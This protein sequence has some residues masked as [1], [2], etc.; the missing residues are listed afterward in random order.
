MPNINICFFSGDISRTGGT[1]RV[2][3]IIAN[4]LVARG[5]NV[6]ILSA[7]GGNK[8]SFFIEPEVHL[9]SL[10]MDQ[11][12]ANLSDLKLI[13]RLRKFIATK[14][15]DYIVDIDVILSYYSILASLF[16][17]TKV[18]SWEHFYYDINVGDFGQRIRRTIARLFALRF[19]FSIV[20]LTEKD[21]KKYLNKYHDQSKVV[22]I[23]NP[24]TPVGDKQSNLINKS[25]VAVGRLAHEKGF[26]L[27]IQ[28]WSL[29]YTKRPDWVLRIVGSGVDY[30]ILQNM[31]VRLGLEKCITF[32]AN[33]ENV[34]K[35]YLDASIYVMTSRFEGFGMV[36]LEA[37]SYGLPIVSFDSDCGP[38]EIV[39]NNYDG[40][41]VEFGDINALAIRMLE[42]MDSESKRIIFGKRARLDNRFELQRIIRQWENIFL[43]N[44]R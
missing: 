31:A 35:F 11:F 27:L 9:Y 22:A 5:F 16:S 26:D 38:G 2:T 25:V 29:V 43:P 10:S 37:K 32:I 14:K 15:I 28:A 42:L 19:S 4:A 13:N 44:E 1:E 34:E 23:N 17:K 36:L 20:V 39:K 7:R 40:Y 30:E 12:S 8:A 6:V 21:R 3:T 41:L 24:I 33:T 18:V